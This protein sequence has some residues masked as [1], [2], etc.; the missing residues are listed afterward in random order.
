M[1]KFDNFKLPDDMKKQME[2]AAKDN[3]RSY[4]P[5][6]KG[7]YVVKL[8]NMEVGE[9]GPSA[10]LPGAPMLKVD[11]V[12][13]EGDKKKQHMFMNKVLYTDRDDDK[14]NMGKLING[15]LGWLQSLDPPTKAVRESITFEDYDQFSELVLD[16]VDDVSVVEYD[17]SYDPD[18]FYSVQIDEC[19]SD[20]YED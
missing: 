2:K 5:L 7:E 11:F 20:D 9:C 17:V 14:W 12:I 16:I 19:Y 4:D 18:A 1:G 13:L 6:P 8:N 3:G 15:V 10:K